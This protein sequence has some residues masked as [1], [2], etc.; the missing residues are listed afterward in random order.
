[1]KT[2][3]NVFWL[4]FRLAYF[5]SNL[6]KCRLPL[7]SPYWYKKSKN[8]MYSIFLICI[9]VVEKCKTNHDSENKITNYKC[10]CKS[11]KQNNKSENTMTNSKTKQQVRKHNDKSDKPEEVGIVWDSAIGLGIDYSPLTG[12]DI[13]Q[14]RYTEPEEE[15]Q[16]QLNHQLQWCRW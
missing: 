7:N 11:K 9:T 3:G 13:C 16:S 5:L 8:K 15:Q 1:M 6:F 2:V 12:R 14:S 4:L 10:K